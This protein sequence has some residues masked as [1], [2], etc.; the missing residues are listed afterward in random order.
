MVFSAL[1]NFS[2]YL[3]IALH[4]W[5]E[6]EISRLKD[7]GKVPNFFNAQRNGPMPIPID[8]VYFPPPFFLAGHHL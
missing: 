8:R 4:Y 5:A 2:I 3:D 7:D 6:T 1:T